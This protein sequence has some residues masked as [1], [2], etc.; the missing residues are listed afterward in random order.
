MSPSTRPGPG[1]SSAR[2]PPRWAADASDAARRAPHRT[3][4]SP[5]ART[6]ACCTPRCS[7]GRARPL[8]IT[9]LSSNRINLSTLTSVAAAGL[10]RGHLL[11][12]PSRTQDGGGLHVTMPSA[13]AVQ[14]PGL[15]AQADLLRHRSRP[16]A[17]VARR[18]A[19][20]ASATSPRVWSWTAAATSHRARTSSSG[21]GTADQPAVATRRPGRRLVPHRQPH[22]CDG[23]GQLG[24]RRQRRPRPQSAWNGGNNQQW[25]LNSLGSGRFQIINRGTG[26][27]LDGAGNST[28]GSVAKLWMPNGSTKTSGP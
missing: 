2:G 27:A 17:P 14:R 18:P 20:C 21:T 7:A 5:A 10:H 3:S 28:A 6:T 24:Q 13:P 4:A 26:T 23:D 19:G 9:T 16:S 25:R 22:Q 11:D 12:L 8:T 1:Q 15:R